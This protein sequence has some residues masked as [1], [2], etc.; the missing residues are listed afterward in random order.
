M[1]QLVHV[2]MEWTVESQNT[3]P[4]TRRRA[5]VALLSDGDRVTSPG[6]SG[7]QTWDAMQKSA[8][9]LD[10]LCGL[11]ERLRA[12]GIRVETLLELAALRC[13]SH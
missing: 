3:K 5:A 12:A 10:E 7:I 9:E 6:R 11:R 1:R 4:W 2:Q 8:I 13:A